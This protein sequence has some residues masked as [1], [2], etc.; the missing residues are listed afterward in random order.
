MKAFTI[1]L[2]LVTA[3]AMGPWAQGYNTNVVLSEVLHLYA[4]GGWIAESP[5]GSEGSFTNVI[6]TDIADITNPGTGFYRSINNG[7]NHLEWGVYELTNGVF[8]GWRVPN[9][10]R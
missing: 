6:Y 2:S 9:N 7:T 1:T 10:N 5:D 8:A 3:L 4:G